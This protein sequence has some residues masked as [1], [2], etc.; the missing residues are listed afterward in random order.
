SIAR[1]VG[2][3][4]TRRLWQLAQEATSI[5]ADRVDRHAIACDL[6]W[7]YL[8]AAVKARQVDEMR[9]ELALWRDV[10][11]YSKGELLDRAE[12]AARVETKA[13]CG[14]MLDLGGGHLHPLNYCLGLAAAAES[15]GVRIF[16][17]SRVARIGGGDKPVLH[18]SR[19][20]VRARHAA[21][22]GGA[23]L[24]NLV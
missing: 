20:T 18:T 1:A 11:G 17:S 14:G 2:P 4:D 19:G 13:Y 15:A 3:D 9:G 7:G 5:I 10:H 22:C 12:G 21:L 23:Y 8:L 24:G 6:A 16:E